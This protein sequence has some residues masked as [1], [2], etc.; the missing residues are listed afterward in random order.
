[1]RRKRNILLMVCL[2]AVV[3]LASGLAGDFSLQP[4][5]Q[6]LDKPVSSMSAV[7]TNADCMEAGSTTRLI[8]PASDWLRFQQFKPG[9]FAMTVVGIV[10]L[11]F[12]V[13]SLKLFAAV[14]FSFDF[15]GV[16]SFIHN[17]DG[18]K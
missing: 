17:K 11:I 3:W 7:Q 9:L 13:L 14:N 12:V 8:S 18:M 2:L 15:C 10:L 6:D 16:I 5:H 4:V 1:M